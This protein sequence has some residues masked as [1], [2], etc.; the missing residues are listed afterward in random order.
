MRLLGLLIVVL[1]LSSIVFSRRLAKEITESQKTIPIRKLRSE[2][3]STN[4]VIA[5]VV[6]T[7]FMVLGALMLAGV[8]TE[9][10]NGW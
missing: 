10:G 8:I 7:W 9:L 2:D 3:V 5:I 1:G 4:R 6:G